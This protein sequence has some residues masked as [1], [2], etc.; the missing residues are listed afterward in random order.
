MGNHK[1]VKIP[2]NATEV[3]DEI[4]QYLKSN[5]IRQEAQFSSKISKTFFKRS[6]IGSFSSKANINSEAGQTALLLSSALN[7]KLVENLSQERY[8]L[9]LY[10]LNI[11]MIT[12]TD[13]PPIDG[14]SDYD[15]LNQIIRDDGSEKYFLNLTQLMKAQLL[16]S[17]N[18]PQ[19]SH[20]IKKLMAFAKFLSSRFNN[21]Y[22]SPFNGQFHHGEII[23]NCKD[24]SISQIETDEQNMDEESEA[25][26][27]NLG[28]SYE[29]NL[30]Q[31]INKEVERVKKERKEIKAIRRQ[32]NLQI[33]KVSSSPRQYN[34]SKLKQHNTPLINDKA[35]NIIDNDFKSKF[36]LTSPN[37]MPKG[38]KPY[39]K[40][41]LSELASIYKKKAEA[42]KKLIKGKN[43][44]IEYEK[45]LIR[46]KLA[47]AKNFG[48]IIQNKTP[49]SARFSSSQ[50]RQNTLH[51][52]SNAY[53]SAET[54]NRKTQKSLFSVDNNNIAKD[55]K[56]AVILNTGKVR[57]SKSNPK[58]QLGNAI[59][60][61]LNIQK[62]KVDN[63]SLRLNQEL[64]DRRKSAT[65]K[66]P[67]LKQADLKIDFRFQKFNVSR[68][69]SVAKTKMI[70]YNQE[71]QKRQ[72]YS[73]TNKQQNY[74]LWK[75]PKH[76]ILQQSKVR[77]EKHTKNGFSIKDLIMQDDHSFDRN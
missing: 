24:E 49:K 44:P 57:I 9:N 2:P 59:I 5:S 70:S 40:S 54:T 63:M 75:S 20:E 72:S 34:A 41:I 19:L 25:R 22:N 47:K 45:F 42:K 71:A 30:S 23:R 35:L 56:K 62:K 60:E 32:D 76:N 6:G 37:S 7:F 1:S 43:R 36:C 28:I 48:V 64:L 61:R 11:L 52:I 55:M 53:S 73:S 12:S 3:I 38:S 15:F 18:P 69:Q 13:E 66:I 10:L 31:Y 58:Y 26:N 27:N 46:L 29:S 4:C 21:M 77:L 16:F 74:K 17:E 39:Q 50:S 8:Y 65:S 33:L 51:T 67:K 14:D 68:P